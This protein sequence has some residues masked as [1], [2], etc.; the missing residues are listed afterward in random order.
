MNPI[1]DISKNQVKKMIM[2]INIFFDNCDYTKNDILD[3]LKE[4]QLDDN[5]YYT[6]NRKMVI[7]HIISKILT[8]III[9]IWYYIFPYFNIPNITRSCR[10]KKYISINN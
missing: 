3:I 4:C 7:H 6:P 8:K 2:D 5:S 10:I 1:E 9:I